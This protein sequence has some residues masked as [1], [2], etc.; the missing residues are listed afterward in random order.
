MHTQGGCRIA[1]RTRHWLMTRPYLR[2]EVRTAEVS[3]NDVILDKYSACK[4]DDFGSHVVNQLPVMKPGLS[5]EVQSLRQERCNA[6]RRFSQLCKYVDVRDPRPARE[7]VVIQYLICPF[8]QECWNAV[9]HCCNVQ[10]VSEIK[11]LAALRHQEP[12][13]KMRS[14][15]A[16]DTLLYTFE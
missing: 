15:H 14:S 6:Y 12:R 1:Q 11:K 16:L 8:P 10:I 3:A 2:K 9:V 5:L 7:Q 4:V 13:N